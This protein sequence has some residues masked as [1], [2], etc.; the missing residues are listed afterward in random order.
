MA[1]CKN[2]GYK[3]NND[4]KFCIKCG[5]KLNESINFDYKNEDSLWSNIITILI[6]LL[7]CFICFW[8]IHNGS[9]ID[10]IVKNTATKTQK[11]HNKFSPS[12]KIKNLPPK[13]NLEV[14]N[15]SVCAVDQFGTMGVCGIIKNNSSRTYIYAQ[16]DINLY[17]SYGNLIATA[18]DNINNIPSGGTWKFMAHPL[19][20][21]VYWFKSYQIVNVS[22]W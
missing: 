19:S 22:G 3:S 4:A 9:Q 14:I 6:V 11:T 2:C 21:G 12:N 1:Y 20:V 16:V 13:E 15:T 7:A 17:D 18:M 5:C 8:L 10:N